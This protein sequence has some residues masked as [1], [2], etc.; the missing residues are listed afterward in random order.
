MVPKSALVS[1]LHPST[2]LT[3]MEQMAVVVEQKATL[4]VV[5]TANY[6]A[7][8]LLFLLLAAT[9][10]ALSLVYYQ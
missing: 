10:L 4:I 3:S 6:Y 8:L 5:P 1:P 9:G 7:S 2:D